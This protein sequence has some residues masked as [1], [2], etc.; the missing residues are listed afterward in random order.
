METEAD[1]E[2]WMKDKRRR[3]QQAFRQNTEKLQRAN[4]APHWEVRQRPPCQH[5]HCKK[6]QRAP[7]TL[8]PLLQADGYVQAP[9]VLSIQ[10]SEN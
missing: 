1:T 9:S 6:L 10:T 3:S 7:S 2:S 8:F 4:L 5:G